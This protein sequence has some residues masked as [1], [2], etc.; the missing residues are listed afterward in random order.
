VHTRDGGE[1]W[2]LQKTETLDPFLDVY[3]VDSRRGCAIGFGPIA[4]TEDGGKTWTCQDN[5]TGTFLWGLHFDF[6]KRGWAVG[7]N[8]AIVFS[9]DG[10][11]S[12]TLQSSGTDNWIFDICRAGDDLW[13]VGLKGM[14]LKYAFVK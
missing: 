11:K 7:A 10:G 12:W 2:E 5:K 8:G 1:K 14:I 4:R 6:P 13:A 3:F 9:E